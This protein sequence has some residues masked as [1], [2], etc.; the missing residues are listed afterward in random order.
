MKYFEY[1]ISGIDGSAANSSD[2]ALITV[3]K[4]FPI[5]CVRPFS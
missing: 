1:E 3:K 4:S 5:V 2:I